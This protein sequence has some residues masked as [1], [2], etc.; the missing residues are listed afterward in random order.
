MPCASQR[1]AILRHAQT[2]DKVLNTDLA[3]TLPRTVQSHVDCAGG[4]RGGTTER[5]CGAMGSNA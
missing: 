5:R 3:A 4:P 2:H 1:L